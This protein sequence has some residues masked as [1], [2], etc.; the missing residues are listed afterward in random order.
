MC[1]FFKER[2]LKYYA[3]NKNSFKYKDMF[4]QSKKNIVKINRS[5]FLVWFLIKINK[6]TFTTE[7]L[8]YRTYA[9]QLQQ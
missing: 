8:S 2:R 7:I 4:I 1:N 3:Q 5:Y 9:V 6:R